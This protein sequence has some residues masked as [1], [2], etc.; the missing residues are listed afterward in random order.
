MYGDTQPMFDSDETRRAEA[1]SQAVMSMDQSSIVPVKART[2]E[3]I[4]RAAEFE[5][6]LKGGLDNAVEQSNEQRPQRRTGAFG[7]YQE[8]GLDDST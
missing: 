3:I 5:A 2:Q 4:A 7:T 8:R 1:L 6:Y